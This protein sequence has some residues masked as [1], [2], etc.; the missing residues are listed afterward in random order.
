MTHNRFSE[1]AVCDAFGI[2]S[3]RLVDTHG[4]TALADDLRSL[5]RTAVSYGVREW[6][7]SIEERYRGYS[8]SHIAKILKEQAG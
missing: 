8:Q 6:L 4:Y 5:A 3:S 1:R 2:D 7:L